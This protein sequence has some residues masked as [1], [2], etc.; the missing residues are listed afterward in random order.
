MAFSLFGLAGVDF[1]LSDPGCVAK[2]FPSFWETWELV[3]R[4]D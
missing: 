1:S 3:R 4:N 2:S